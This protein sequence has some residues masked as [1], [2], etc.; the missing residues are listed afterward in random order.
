MITVSLLR[1][2]NEKATRKE[3]KKTDDDH[4]FPLTWM[5]KIKI[6]ISFLWRSIRL[7]ILLY[8]KISVCFP[9]TK[10]ICAKSSDGTRNFWALGNAS[11]NWYK[12][13]K[14]INKRVKI[15]NKQRVLKKRVQTYTNLNID[16]FIIGAVI[17]IHWQLDVAE[18]IIRRVYHTVFL[19]VTEKTIVKFPEFACERDYVCM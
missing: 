10:S 12:F 5:H 17:Q 19:H 3:Q 9:H 18:I 4:S 11:Y 14:N 1:L 15:L 7:R 16:K 6:Y 2:C 13:W 8:T